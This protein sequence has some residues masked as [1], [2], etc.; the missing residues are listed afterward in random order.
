MK[1]SSDSDG[2][3][4]HQIRQNEQ[5]PLIWYF[6]LWSLSALYHIY[7]MT[8]G[9]IGEGIVKADITNLPVK[10]PHWVGVRNLCTRGFGAPIH[11]S[12]ARLVVRS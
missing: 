8:T 5:P 6:W 10:P 2:Q 12:G 7:I 11:I 9:L 3:L 1:E 4:F